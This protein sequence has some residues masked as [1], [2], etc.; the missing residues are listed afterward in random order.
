M[1]KNM[2]SKGQRQVSQ[3]MEQS[4][5]NEGSLVGGARRD[6]NGTLDYVTFTS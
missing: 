4:I 6:E 5:S 2:K 1:T 3:L